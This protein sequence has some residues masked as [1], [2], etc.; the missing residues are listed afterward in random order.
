MT[1]ARVGGA[2]LSA[3]L[4]LVAS[5]TPACDFDAAYQ[6]WCEKNGCDG[7]L[8]YR[9][10]GCDSSD[11]VCVVLDGAASCEKTCTGFPDGCPAGLDCKPVASAYQSTLVPACVPSGTSTDLCSGSPLECAPA[12]TCAKDF[13]DVWR[14]REICSPFVRACA[15]AE[16]ECVTGYYGFPEEWGYCQ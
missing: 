1:R 8:A 9:C 5:L 11:D 13:L 6:S 14:C 3:V 2:L 4:P 15:L 16:Q 7:G 12:Y 10:E